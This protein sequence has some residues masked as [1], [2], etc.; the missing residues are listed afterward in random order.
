MDLSRRQAGALTLATML[1]A[2]SWRAQAASAGTLVRSDGQP[3]NLD[4]HQVF[5]VPMMGYALNTYDTLYR[6]EGNPP[7]MQPWLAERPHRLGRWP[8][9]GT[10]TLRQ[11]TRSSTTGQRRDRGRRGVQLP[12]AC[13]PWA[14]APASAFLADPEAGARDARRTPATVRF[15]L[16]RPYGPFLSAIPIVAI[17]N[18]ARHQ[19]ER[20]GRGIGAPPG[21]RPTRP[22][23]ARTGWMPGK[24]HADRAAGPPPESPDHFYG[25]ADNP[26]PVETVLY[27]LAHETSTGV[28][29]LLNGS[30]DMT[31]SYLPTDQVEQIQASKTARVEKAT[32]MRVFVI[33]MNNSKPPFDNLNARKCVCPRLQ[34]HAGSSTDILKGYADRDGTP[35]PNTLWGYPEGRGGLR[36]RPR[37]GPRLH[38]EGDGGGCADEAPGGDPHPVPVGADQPGGATVPERPGK[39]SASTSRWSATPGPT[40]RATPARL[41]PRR[42]CGSTGSARI[43]SIRRT[44]SGQMYDSQFA[45]TWKAS[46][47]YKSAAVDGLLRQARGLVDQAAAAADSTSRRRGRSWPTAWT[48]GSTTRWSCVACRGGSRISSSARW[49]VAGRCVGC[50]WPDGRARP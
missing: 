12:A 42:T 36:V 27:R 13:S 22:G 3:Q 46:S 7:Q 25:W 30:I 48:C 1:A 33:R 34:L 6:Y 21:S 19:A 38:E 40:S 31:D 23:R 29:G 10:F 4:P 47:W 32:S 2:G 49:G 20:E 41:I 37:Q 8:G 45:G 35:M 17:V 16:E 24:L 44:G 18:P 26:K 15:Q 43:S 39:A 9:P 28:L 50:S 11:G 14:R 5:D